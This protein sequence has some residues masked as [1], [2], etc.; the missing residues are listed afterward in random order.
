MILADTN[1]FV[2]FWANPDED[3]IRV[4]ESEEVVICGVVRAELLHGAVSEKDF[5]R[6]STL[7]S[8]F[9]EQPFEVKDWQMLGSNLYKLR[10]GGITV[11]ISDA[12]IATISIKHGIPVWTRDKHF[13]M[14]QNVLSE[15]KLYKSE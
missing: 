1:V 9:E 2:D 5:N 12:I 15:L 13:S 4:F 8:A 6:I 11:P 3:T 14:I 10:T 7:L